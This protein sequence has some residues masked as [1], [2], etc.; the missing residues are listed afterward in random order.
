MGKSKKNSAAQIMAMRKA[1]AGKTKAPT[2]KA[3]HAKSKMNPK[4]ISNLKKM[5]PYGGKK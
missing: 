2:A 1:I 5:A 3:D 4:A